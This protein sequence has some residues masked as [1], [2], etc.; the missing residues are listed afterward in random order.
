MNSVEQRLCQAGLGRRVA[1]L[2]GGSILCG[3]Y[4]AGRVLAENIGQKAE[5]L[6]ALVLAGSTAP[7]NFVGVLRGFQP[8][9]VVL[10]DAA[11]MGLA[12]GET[13]VI[14]DDQVAGASF[15]THMLPLPILLSYL[16]GELGCETLM[17]GV[18]PAC[19]DFGA[20]PC[21][22]VLHGVESLGSALL[23]FFGE[24]QKKG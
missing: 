4:G 19:T 23:Q 8:G 1:V 22:Q 9:L 12:P 16:R 13:A 20:Q 21:P 3:D 17:I 2:C 5:E 11:R 6:G 7:E 10:V 15:S 18:E 24:N 14:E